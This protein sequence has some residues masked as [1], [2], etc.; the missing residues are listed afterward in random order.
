MELGY[1]PGA[2]TRKKRAQR[3]ARGYSGAGI[4]YQKTQMAADKYAMKHET[5]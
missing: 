5:S 3:M 2:A 1:L 4:F